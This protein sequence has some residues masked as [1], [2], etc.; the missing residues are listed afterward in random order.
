MP[1]TSSSSN[2]ENQQPLGTSAQGA[3]A[4]SETAT[5]P[6]SAASNASDGS[7]QQQQQQS[8]HGED[9]AARE[10]RIRNAAY[11]AYVRRGGEPGDEVQ[12]WLD[13]ESQVDGRKG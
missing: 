10:E 6:S 7:G 1:K 4:A 2:P 3:G 12:D 13:A 8:M 9:P 5:Q 11:D